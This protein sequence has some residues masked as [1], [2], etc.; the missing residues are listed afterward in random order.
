M[1]VMFKEEWVGLL[2]SFLMDGGWDCESYVCGRV[3]GPAR[4]IFERG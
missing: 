2:E 1:T 3:S 4:F